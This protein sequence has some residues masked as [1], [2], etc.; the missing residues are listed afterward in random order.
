MTVYKNCQA[1]PSTHPSKQPL[2]ASPAYL[3]TS[4][5]VII[6]SAWLRGSRSPVCP[7]ALNLLLLAFLP[8]TI[9]NSL[10]VYCSYPYFFVF[11]CQKLLRYSRVIT[12]CK[13]FVFAHLPYHIFLKIHLLFES[14]D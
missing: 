3:N 1:L 9:W 10:I 4:C 2:R 6:K 11:M 5:I 13:F 14:Y 8:V 7:D 12:P